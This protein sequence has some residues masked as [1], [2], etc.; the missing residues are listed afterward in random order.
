MPLLLSVYTDP[1]FR[2]LGLAS[3]CTKAAMDWCR[4]QGF[5]S[6]TLHASKKGRG[7]YQGLGWKRTWEM[8][9]SLA[10]RAR[11]RGR[12]RGTTTTTPSRRARSA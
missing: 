12:R 2:R 7:V 6:M 4:A 10:P 3:R 5:P 8:G 1:R 11:T 9:V